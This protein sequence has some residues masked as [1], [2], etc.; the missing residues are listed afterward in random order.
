MRSPTPQGQGETKFD[1]K[2]RII[3]F[4]FSPAFTVRKAN[5]S[6]FDP[7]LVLFP[8]ADYQNNL[9]IYQGNTLHPK[10]SFIDCGIMQGDKIILLDQEQIDWT[11]EIFWKNVSKSES[12]MKRF[13]FPK[14]YRI[15][16]REIARL[17]D[18][19]LVRSE[20][21]RFA[22]YNLVQ[23]LSFLEDTSQKHC[24]KT[25]INYEK[26]EPSTSPLPNIFI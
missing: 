12:A 23:Q 26:T 10:L 11:A 19:K 4:V 22:F 5:V 17:D 9:I 1:Q 18:L 14:L 7:L 25:N 24:F 3:I 21:R 6:L 16:K 13:A 15:F 2:D 20:T 8:M